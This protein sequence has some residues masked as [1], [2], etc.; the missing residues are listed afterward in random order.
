[1]I[2]DESKR[3][4][5][6]AVYQAMSEEERAAY[7]MLSVIFV[8][9]S[10]ANFAKTLN[11]AGIGVP[12]SPHKWNAQ[13]DAAPLLDRWERKG[14]VEK[15]SP[16]RGESWM[17]VRLMMEPAA[18]E[19][20]ANGEFKRFDEAAVKTL[21]IR[22]LGV[23]QYESVPHYLRALRGVF[24]RGSVKEY[25]Q[26]V[27]TAVQ[28]TDSRYGSVRDL[29]PYMEI[30][31]NPLDLE[32]ISS[33]PSRIGRVAFKA[34]LMD[35]FGDPSRFVETM[36]ALGA[37]Q[38]KNQKDAMLNLI[39][40][41]CGMLAGQIEEA[42]RTVEKE[43]SA[44][45]FSI[46]ALGALTRGDRDGALALY[47]E[48]I[49]HLR[50]ATGK[51]KVVFYSWTSFFYPILLAGGDVPAKK[52]KDYVEALRESRFNMMWSSPFPLLR[53]FSETG[54]RNAAF[55]DVGNALSGQP[56]HAVD[57]FF[58]ILCAYWLNVDRTRGEFRKLAEAAWRR[59]DA[60]GLRFLSAELA[61]LIRELWPEAAKDYERVPVPLHPLKS[62]M[63]RQTEWERSLHALSGIGVRSDAALRGSKRFVWEISWLSRDGNPTRVTLAPMEQTMQNAGWSKGRP[64]ALKRLYQKAD[65]LPG[66]TD[67]DHRAVSAV[68]EDRGYYGTDYYI[69]VPQALEAL[70]GHPYLFREGDGGRVDVV[71]DEPQLTAI[72]D[73]DKY[74]LR[75]TPFPDGRAVPQHAIREDGPACLR[76]TRFEER[77]VRI[78][79]I[80]GEN[81]LLVPERAKDALLK[82]LGSLA[83]VVTIHS[84]IEGIQANAEQ[85]GADARIYV[86]IQ[87][88]GDG[89]DVE[90]IVRPLGP[91][92]VPCRPGVGGSSLFGLADS[93]RVQARRSLDSEKDAL[94]LAMRGCPAL[95]DAEQITDERWHLQTPELSLEFLLQ[96]QEL[97]DSVAV[98]WPRGQTMHVRSQVSISSMNVAVRSAQEWFSLSGELRIDEQLVLSMKDL[99]EL[100]R[101][102]YGRF[103]PVGEG[104]FVALTKE[105]RRRIEALTA[106]GDQRGDE[107]RVSPLLAGLI[108][109]LVD[110]A[111]SFKG[112][113]EWER[114]LRL[115]DEAA[116]L[117]PR[118]PS[119][120]RGEMRQY[121]IE[122]YRWMSRLAHWDAGAC[123]AD[124]M[125]LGKTVQALALL[126]S[127][128]AS[129]PA[130]VV[131]PTSVCSNWVD[132]ARRFAPTL[133]MK[134][135]RNGDRE[136]TLSDLG[137][138]DVVVTTYGLLQNEIE[139]LSA[140]RWRTIIL[141]EAQAIKNMGTKRSA[142]AMKLQGDFRV[143]TTGTPIENHLGELWNLFRFL[144]PHF[145]GSLD[146]F[147]RR[148]AI[149][150]ERD[151]NPE[152][153]QRLKKVIQPFILRRNKEQ[154]LE[155]L[156]PKTEVT[157]RVDMKE[158]EKAVYEALRQNAVEELNAPD[159]TDQRF[160]IFAELMRLRRAC[161]NV[162]LVMPEKGGEKFPSAKLEAFAEILAELRENNHKALVFSQFVD[163][164]TIIR[165]Y[166]DGEGIAYQ[167]L[168]G[169]TPPQERRNR[170][171]AFQAGE[172][173]CF[174]ISLKAGG[175]GLNLTAADYVI[176]MDPWWNP[177]VEEQASDRAHRIGQDRPVTV[178]RIVAKD[179]IEEKIV[180]LHAWKRDLAESLLDESGTPARLSAEAMLALIQEAR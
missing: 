168:D 54:M 177:A 28:G 106:L 18:R 42:V 52:T 3:E 6:T 25:E 105:F 19:A 172:G 61:V 141:D 80:L 76:V 78:A 163:H 21:N 96:V 132:E 64:V 29:N 136:Q 94:M 84:D 48:G 91:N 101:A 157:L 125:G 99:I 153:R 169:S 110:E 126:L 1:M 148:F 51:R 108:A 15:G 17:C 111:G 98:E 143:I 145:L 65:T 35:F 104:Q 123:L 92:G 151:G 20:L 39:Q 90:M 155:E 112:N 30:F 26:V 9:V 95:M 129:G 156:P 124:D 69:D 122:G 147:N 87:P 79:E 117:D 33:L 171:H 72:Y 63:A 62:L 27:F 56:E 140:L 179:T 7:R 175:T 77:H 120:F 36:E 31:G 49:K 170:V 146:S 2:F 174:L 41:D 119:T 180:D 44:E 115:I 131:A 75:L 159:A 83:S 12:G 100:L 53:P 166:L 70:A 46:R 107:L 178:Y 149:P 22:D 88:S 150:I 161:C 133:V 167:Y 82:A 165:K 135:L 43:E 139:R 152:A 118:L 142:A 127:R 50:K 137:P 158:E 60:L 121:Q 58:F 34:L 68:R 13:R 59:L 116:K 45:S 138:L 97:G 176:H 47:E 164:L 8:P 173:D 37:Y 71:V 154:V 23:F 86:Q 73:A 67:Q 32:M 93:K 74:R 113:V 55:F 103:L 134:E 57:I 14:M 144:N 102:G 40:A 10:T 160:K 11:Q 81:G 85:V 16:G 5:L 114:Q 89:L 24:F 4:K 130:L 66:M 128:G 38:K 162:S 109:P